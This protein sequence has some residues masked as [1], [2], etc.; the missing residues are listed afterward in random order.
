[1]AAAAT[2]PPRHPVA[3][4]QAG[5]QGP[6]PKHLDIESR[7][8]TPPNNSPVRAIPYNRPAN[9]RPPPRASAQQ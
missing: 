4:A 9:A 7:K 3:P 8:P 1:M 6:G 2:P 5:A